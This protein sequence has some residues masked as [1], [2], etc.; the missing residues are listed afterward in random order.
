VA[1]AVLFLLDRGQPGD[2]YNICG[3]EEVDNLRLAQTI[4]E[5]LGRPLRYELVDFHSSRPGHDLRYALDGR[6][7]A[8]M[9]F[10]YECDFACGLKRTVEWYLANQEW[11]A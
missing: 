9:G 3:V 4:A 11:L 10:A 2:K 8:S 6:K 1:Q 7:L 5:L